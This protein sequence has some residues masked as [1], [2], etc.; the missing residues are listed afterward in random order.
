MQNAMTSLLARELS[1]ESTTC[2]RKPRCANFFWGKK[3]QGYVNTD[4]YVS[5]IAYYTYIWGR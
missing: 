1:G 4:A 5:S 2:W 3:K